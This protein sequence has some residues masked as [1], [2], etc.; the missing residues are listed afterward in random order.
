MK[1]Q[2]FFNSRKKFSI[3]EGGAMDGVGPIHIDE[4]E[5]T[6][7]SLEKV[8]KID[9]KNN[10]LGSVGKRTLSGEIDVALQVEPD[11]IPEFIY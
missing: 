5:P 6:L 10:V 2:E 8:L 9:L 3:S 11:Q 1:L 7:D 4:I